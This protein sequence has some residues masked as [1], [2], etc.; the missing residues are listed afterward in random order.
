MEHH[1][2]Q[3]THNQTA[4]PLTAGPRS[5]HVRNG[6]IDIQQ[7]LDSMRARRASSINALTSLRTCL[8]RKS[9]QPSIYTL[10]R[11]YTQCWKCLPESI[12][13]GVD[14]QYNDLIE[15]TLD[16]VKSRYQS[17]L[18]LLPENH[19]GPTIIDPIS[20]RSIS[21]RTLASFV[22]SFKLPGVD[23]ARPVVALALPNSPLLGL[24]SIAVA[25]YY[26]LAPINV[27]SGADQ[28]QSDVLSAGSSTIV[29]LGEHVEQLGLDGDWVAQHGIQVCIVHPK[30]DLTCS[31]STLDGS[32]K[33][34]LITPKPNGPDDTCILLF[35]SGT[36]GTKKLVPITLHALISAVAFI[37]SSW[38]LTEHDVCLNMMPLNHIGGLARNLFAPILLG[39]STICC[40]AFDPNLFW[41]LVLEGRATWYYA[42]PSMH[43]AILNEAPSQQEVVHKSRIRMVCNAA[44]GLLPSLST[45]L[46]ETFNSTI[47]PSYG[48]TECMPI[49]T[50]PIDYQLDRPGTSGIAVGPELG[51]LDA[52]GQQEQTGTIGRVCVRGNPVFPGYLIN[53]Q[54]DKS[55]FTTDGWFDTGDLGYLDADG[56][57]YITGRSKEVINRGG[58]IISPFEVEEAIMTASRRV[59]SPIYGRIIESLAFSAPHDTLQEVVGVAVVT[60]PGAPRVD[61]RQIHDAVK[62]SLHSTKWPVVLVYMDAVPKRNGKLCRVKL[63]ER[64]GFGPIQDDLQ[65]VARHFEAVCPVMDAPISMQI[66]K[67]VCQIDGQQ[68]I[69]SISSYLKD[70][71]DVLV[72]PNSNTGFLDAIIAPKD[73][74]GNTE[75]DIGQLK[76]YLQDDLPGYL[77]PGKIQ[78]INTPFPRS[79]FGAIDT[80]ALDSLLSPTKLSAITKFTSPTEQKLQEIF[81][82]LLSMPIED[83]SSDSDFFDL[84]GDSLRAGRLL[85]LIRKEFNSRI[86]IDKLFA[87]SR[88]CDISTMI[89]DYRMTFPSEKEGKH[90][91]PTMTQTYSSTSLSTLLIHLL[92]ISVFSPLQSAFHLILFLKTWSLLLYYFRRGETSGNLFYLVISML[93]ARA[94]EGSIYPLI[95]I[96][97]KWIIIGRYNEGL[98][99]MWSGYHNRWWLVSKI[100]D[101]C[102]IGMFKHYPWSRVL[103]YRLMGAKIGRNVLIQPNTVLGEYDL[104]D[105]GDNVE[106]DR[107]VCRGFAV[108]HNTTMYLGKIRMGNGSAAGM[109]T[110][111]APGTTVP[112]DVCLGVNSSSWEAQDADPSNFEQMA[113]RIP[114]PHWLLWLLVGLPIM[115]AIATISRLPWLAGLI[116]LNVAHAP[117]DADMMLFLFGWFSN[118]RRVG[119]HFLAR[120]MNL[121]IA[122]LLRMALIILLKRSTDLIFGKI[123]PGLAS[124]R[125][126][127]DRFRMKLLSELIPNGNI[128]DVTGFFGTHYEITS[129]VVR[130]LGGKVGKRVYWPGNGPSIQ[131]FDLLDIGND[132]VFGS[133]ARLLTSDGVGCD[134]VRVDDGAM[135][136]DRVI[137]LPGSR[138]GR[139][140][141]L[142]S[143]SLSRRNAYYEPDSIWIGAKAGGPVRLTPRSS[144]ASSA[145]LISPRSDMA[146]EF[147]NV[148]TDFID[149]E[150]KVLES[151]PVYNRFPGSLDSTRSSMELHSFLSD[152]ISEASL[153]T[154]SPFGRAFYEGQAPYTVLNLWTITA[155][156]FA[157]NI[158][159]S[160]YW[161]L[162]NIL[163]LQ[164]LARATK[165]PLLAPYFAATIYRPLVA[166]GFVSVTFSFLKVSLSILALLICI[167]AKWVLIGRRTPGSYDW[168]ASSYCQRWKLYLTIERIR[169]GHFGGDDIL[170]MLTGTWFIATY[171]RLLGARIGSDCALYAGGEMTLA[172]TEPDL[173]T[174]GDRVAV[175]DA[176]L[177]A[178][179]NSRGEFKLNTLVIGDRGVMRTG[180]R[181]L[182]GAS[183]AKD[184]CLLEHTLVMG[185]DEV[186]NGTTCQGWPAE[187]FMAARVVLEDT[188]DMNEKSERVRGS[189]W[190]QFRLLRWFRG[191]VRYQRVGAESD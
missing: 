53:G 130:A 163:T 167:V 58:E 141:V 168:D 47:L 22:Q 39:G 55:A 182:S 83:V 23:P 90:T 60:T 26:T 191:D 50:P 11:C 88:V 81:A 99:P 52:A 69:N 126:Q 36:T 57:L 170:T 62:K 160:I 145:T 175:D 165:H 15:S 185:G 2:Q 132:V 171:F 49:S 108:E 21:Q 74:S 144:Q 115:G 28:F 137:M 181:L 129:I 178:H 14:D 114:D 4:G 32:A 77:I 92:P 38:N 35:T 110:V 180:S 133:Q 104:L 122:P 154:S 138:I 64:L 173:V 95:G 65:V 27:N 54:I 46:R 118:P 75:I 103:Y 136:A 188:T 159:V 131:N 16:L 73:D 30:D 63:G 148:T 174:L 179:I 143:G 98:Y 13:S 151:D 147:P 40:S 150:K 153:P 3:S 128:S 67:N 184:S 111:V 9:F 100:L 41:D 169:R 183:M 134:I 101:N 189:R 146:A 71:V 113:S 152:S 25:T 43:S 18:D 158:L 85:S 162:P 42:S 166:I 149:L 117:M 157:T 155:Y 56:Y 6:S 87:F 79:L 19:G 96:A 20:H 105:I 24:V 70:K 119:F 139:N 17:L 31:I 97:A 186:E 123:Q 140:A 66:N 94:I 172:C 121:C 120:I 107:C 29:V 5:R 135:V 106:L 190:A 45:Q 116:G 82:D 44:G 161:N 61:L 125:S 34:T 72:K 142:G 33:S 80:E 176:S 37:G 187:D 177:V 51:I 86:P 156:S 112:E 84:G 12:K 89:E 68:T 124:K 109:K 164:L 7:L 102:G 78:A 8:E 76:A 91:T 1:G 10:I 93:V 59:G 48:M 127:L